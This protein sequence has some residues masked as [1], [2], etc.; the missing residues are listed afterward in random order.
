MISRAEKG[1]EFVFLGFKSQTNNSYGQISDETLK[2]DIVDAGSQWDD[3]KALR[4]RKF[5]FK[6]KIYNFNY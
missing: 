4:V 6:S 2:Q 1:F 3:I 5:R